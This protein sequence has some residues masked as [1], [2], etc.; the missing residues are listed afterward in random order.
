MKNLKLNWAIALLLITSSWL[1]ASAQGISL[2]I[3]DS[4][5][6]VSTGVQLLILLTILSVAPAILLMTTGFVRIV[7]VFSMLRQAMGIGQLP[8]NQ[9]IIGLSLILTF[10][11]MHPTFT[12][13]NENALQPFIKQE[14]SQ[15]NF[16]KKAMDPMRKFM[17]KQTRES[18]LEMTM[19]LAEIE[20]PE[21]PEDIASHILVAAFILSELKT[22][23]QIGFTIFLPFII[24][25]LI[26]ASALVSMGLMFLPPTTISLPFKV[27]LFVLIDGWAILS[28]ALVYGFIK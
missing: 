1:N 17:L 6:G 28:E 27:I 16:F 10:L 18:D 23:F 3:G 7:I 11:I 24:I 5:E 12:E 4:P 2:Q 22:A 14:I 15:E 13:V 8:P 9:V 26:T 25:D 20:N 19:K 21:K